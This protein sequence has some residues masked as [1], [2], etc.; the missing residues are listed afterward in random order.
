MGVYFRK[1]K[2]DKCR[3]WWMTFT[4]NG[5][6]VQECTYQTTRRGALDYYYKRVSEIRSKTNSWQG[7][8]RFHEF[9]PIYLERYARPNKLSWK[10]S[11]ESYL[12]QLNGYFG[13]YYL[14]K[15][16][17]AMIDDWVAKARATKLRL[18]KEG[19]PQ[20]LSPATVN[21][22]L[23]CLKTLFNKAIE[24]GYLEVSP[25]ARVKKL[26]EDNQRTRFLKKEEIE[27]FLAHSS[28]ELQ[29]IFTILI[30]TGMRKGELQKLK[31]A[32]L[33]FNRGLIGLFQTKS[34]KIRYIPMT[35]AVKAALLKRRIKKQ[36]ETWVFPGDSGKPFNF[37]KAFE[38]ARKKAG[39]NDLRVHDL[40]HTFA[41]HLCMS[42][43]D[44]MTV[45]E[46]LGHS[47]LKMTER[48][49]HLTDYHKA[50]AVAMLEKS[51]PFATTV[52]LAGKQGQTQEFDKI[53]S[54][55]K[56]NK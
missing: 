8:V 47:S 38:T 53:V 2:K 41:S 48:Y 55:L 21:R 50:Q 43:A 6:R 17:Q 44:I 42:G 7:D 49:S 10:C 27:R 26:K 52:L 33:D 1:K 3:K 5:R 12:R 34:G 9:A 15:I 11:D 56:S 13:N 37:R 18:T 4:R 30:H 22:K 40:R 39:L 29:E 36:S 28:L 54:S 35:E 19:K 32:D 51:L 45:K 46:L 31:W 20:Y 25:C 16:T 14:S 23:A 24:W